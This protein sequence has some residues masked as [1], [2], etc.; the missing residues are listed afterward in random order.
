ML[1]AKRGKFTKQIHR[2]ILPSAALI[3]LHAPGPEK[4][5]RF[6]KRQPP[7]PIAPNRQ[8]EEQNR[9]RNDRLIHLSNP[10]F[11]FDEA[12]PKPGVHCQAP[13]KPPVRL[14]AV[15]RGKFR[16]KLR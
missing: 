11:S 15:A 10:H 2:I 13:T 4:S 14:G 16:T 8:G 1:T 12:T 5:P 9:M 6:I 3:C 7:E